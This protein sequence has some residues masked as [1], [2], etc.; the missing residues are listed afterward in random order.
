M[1]DKRDFDMKFL[2]FAKENGLILNDDDNYSIQELTISCK[3]DDFPLVTLK[4]YTTGECVKEITNW[5]KEF[6]GE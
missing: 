4:Y 2:E 5:R 6:E 3:V 1:K